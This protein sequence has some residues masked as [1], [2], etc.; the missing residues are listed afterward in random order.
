MSQSSLR[1][2]HLKR[3]LSHL[4]H[5]RKKRECKEMKVIQKWHIYKQSDYE[6]IQWLIE[7]ITNSI[8]FV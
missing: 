8:Q 4:S 3:P 5:Q 2:N 6:L 1:F 7:G